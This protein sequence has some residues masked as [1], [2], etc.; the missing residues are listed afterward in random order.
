[1]SDDQTNSPADDDAAAAP[2]APQGGTDGDKSLPCEECGKD[3]IFTAGEQEFYEEK[4][5]T[6]PKRCPECRAAK[7]AAG[8]QFTKVTCAGCGK[9]TEVPFVPSGDRPVYC[10]ECFESQKR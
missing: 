7:K 1:M 5:F 2:E 10:R 8:R 4:G 9:E 3:F 6:P